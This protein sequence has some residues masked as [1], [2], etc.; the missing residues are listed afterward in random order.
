MADTSCM[1]LHRERTGLFRGLPNR[2]GLLAAPV[3]GLA[4]VGRSA[5]RDE[6]AD[7]PPAAGS[8]IPRTSCQSLGSRIAGNDHAG[9]DLHD[10]ALPGELAL[11]TSTTTHR[12]RQSPACAESSVVRRTPA[13][14][15]VSC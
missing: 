6:R 3:R 10:L 9:P 13:S 11:I 5:Y 2:A 8:G 12:R 7:L 15:V 4:R 1:R 14:R